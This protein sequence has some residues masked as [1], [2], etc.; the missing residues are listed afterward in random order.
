MSHM[1]VSSTCGRQQ[2]CCAHQRCLAALTV[3]QKNQLLAR[4]CSS[5][6]ICDQ[7]SLLA[8]VR[9]LYGVKKDL[10]GL[11][12]GR[13]TYVIGKD[14]VVK[15]VRFKAQNKLSGSQEIV[16]YPRLVTASTC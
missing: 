15:L 6:S 14:G 10:L 2:C 11:L 13:E 12:E 9:Q 3:Q 1:I 4:V 7:G 5:P 8:Q 16:L